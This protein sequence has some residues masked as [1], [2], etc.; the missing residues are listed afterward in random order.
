[1]RIA[2]TKLAALAVGLATACSIIS[3]SAVA[4]A[5]AA[6]APKVEPDPSA[7]PPDV[8]TIRYSE[9]YRYVTPAGLT[10]YLVDASVARFSRGTVIDYCIAACAAN[11][12][13]LAAAPNALPI[14]LWRPVN[15]MSGRI[16]TYR[17]SPVFTFNADKHPGDVG[18]AGFENALTPVD[19][20][21]RPPA[22][23]APPAAKAIY[24]KGV[25]FLSDQD[26][27]A[28][29]IAK[30]SDQCA[31]GC[32]PP[33]PFRAGSA[34]HPIG[35]WTKVNAGGFTQWAWRKQPVFVGSVAD[36]IPAA[37]GFEPILLAT[38]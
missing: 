26:G 15:S 36:G 12:R 23:V 30:R 37:P 21:P 17:Q 28:L 2:N 34:A 27:H 32:E 13:A 11:F 6:L 1:M 38:R 35:A 25:W 24:A 22:Y 7:Y 9:G 8:K 20:M 29:F 33:E 10:L 5:Q 31:D 14:G 4:G 18:G 3:L 19:Y 16:W